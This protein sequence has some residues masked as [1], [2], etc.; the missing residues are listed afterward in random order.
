MSRI[1]VDVSSA[2]IPVL[3][4]GYQGEN[5]VTDVLFDI[6]SWIT[7]FG[8]GVAQLRV[9]RPG[10]SE[11]ESYVL[12]L[13]ITDGKAVWTVSETDTANK[14][15]GKVQL[16]YMVGNI[17]K[18][19]V[20][21]PYK[22]GKSIVGA[23]SPV[24][25]FD[26]WIERSKA[27]AIGETL[28]GDDVP[29]TDETYQN[30]A[31]YYAEQADI[32]GSAQVVLAAEKVTLAAEQV[33]LATEKAD[34][35]A[36]S[37]AA[38]NGVSTQLTTRMSAIET[39]QAVQD[40]RMDTFTSLPE[41]ST[42]GN[43]E[44]ADIRVGADGI[45]YDTAGNAVRGQIG[46]LKSDITQFTGNER[47]A[48]WIDGKIYRIDTDPIDLTPNHEDPNYRC[49]KIACS[50]NDVF[51][52]N[53]GSLGTLANLWA[54]VSS[55]GER[56]EYE[57][58][59]VTVNNKKLTAPSNAAYLLVNWRTEIDG[60][61][62]IVTVISGKPLV[63]RVTQCE[64]SITKLDD[65]IG[66]ITLT[67]ESGGIDIHLGTPSTHSERLRT[68]SYINSDITNISAKTGYLVIL[69]AYDANDTYKGIWNTTNN[70]FGFE[71]VKTSYVD[72]TA[73]PLYKTYKYKVV[74]CRA[75]D[76]NISV[77]ESVN[78]TNY[79]ANRIDV[80]EEEYNDITENYD[81]LASGYN[82][83]S[84]YI[85][86][87]E[88]V[89]VPTYSGVISL[90]DA[91]VIANPNYVSKNTLTSG[92]FSNY[93][94]VFSMGNYNEKR[95]NR[96]QDAET[97][98][99]VILIMSGVHGHERCSVMGLYLFAKALCE[100][101]AMSAIRDNY[102]FKL[103]PIVCPSGYDAN[104]RV[105]S[106]GVNI[107][108]NFDAD[109]VPTPAD[110][111]NYSGA[112]PADQAE[113]QVVQAWMDENVEALIAIDWH[114]SGYA[115]EVSYFATCL[116]T[117]FAPIAKK[118]YF[119]GVAHIIGHLAKDREIVG[120][121]IIYSYTGISND[122]GYS[123]G[124]GKKIGLSTALLET[125]LDVGDYGMDSKATIGVNAEVICAVIKGI[126]QEMN[127]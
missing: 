9:K 23:D 118:G 122:P 73:I 39:E 104:S 114:N 24:D 18:K 53:G 48:N 57:A 94:Y 34:A 69:Y 46:E 60:N 74:L 15:N 22:V 33:T 98:K 1:S 2:R 29:E 110:G 77:G 50:E 61:P 123:T 47:Y 92:T 112:S 89:L 26:S 88:Q 59:S 27:W 121:N 16:S 81:A 54:F 96:N 71:L 58:P 63:D 3:Q 105:N 113:T 5:E 49:M 31:K 38:V 44:L 125:S 99:P 67:W 14:G 116:S 124:Y 25:P 80:L 66:E 6:S 120:N 87:D 78:V 28:Y 103:I 97:P 72:I 85:S 93:E 35:A 76:G 102:V 79:P 70:A 95:G 45:T 52:I 4:V 117:G 75:D 56:L 101:P 7:E 36:A 13:T 55:T 12:S 84:Y 42:S 107:N 21:Y 106:N 30:N 40:A 119:D 17:V 19:A 11:E 64:T 91:L 100:S 90:Y 32:L 43:A 10:N 68:I 108:R 127:S 51:F 126:C 86:K 20:I 109:W 65:S 111:N 37:E 41:G 8:E 62:N 83:A 82:S 115:A